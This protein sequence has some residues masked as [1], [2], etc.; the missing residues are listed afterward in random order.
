MRVGLFITCFNDAL[1]PGTGAAVVTLLERLGHEVTF[2][3]AQ[4]CCGQLHWTTGYH[5]E[6][7]GLAR[8]FADVCTSL[9]SENDLVVT[10]SASCAAMVRESYPRLMPDLAPAPAAGPP[11]AGGTSPG[12]GRPPDDDPARGWRD[13]VYELSE[14][15]VDVLGI[16]DVGAYFPHRVTYHPTCHSLRALK[17][18]DRPRRLLSAVRGLDL[19]ELPAAEECCGFGGAFAMKNADVSVAIVAD[20]IRHIRTTAADVVCAVDNACLTH[21]GGALSRLRSGVRVMHLA[22]ILAE[23]R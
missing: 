10:P 18:G 9:L 13:N 17:V 1:F 8:R 23:T 22:E 11:A 3:P 19:V 15:L 4:T 12:D 5:R 2:E 20:K 7:A 21:I 14:F 16:T 6:A